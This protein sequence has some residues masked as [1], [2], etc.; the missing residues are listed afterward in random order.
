M[1]CLVGSSVDRQRSLCRKRL[2]A[3]QRLQRGRF[4]GPVASNRRCGRGPFC[5]IRL[6]AKGRPEY[7]PP[8]RRLSRQRVCSQRAYGQACMA[9]R[10]LAERLPRATSCRRMQSGAADA[11][12]DCARKGRPR[13]RGRGIRPVMTATFGPS[14]GSG[15]PVRGR[16]SHR[17]LPGRLPHG[18]R[19]GAAAHRRRALAIVA[20]C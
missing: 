16:G 4:V 19:D 3:P 14:N 13:A 8:R 11:F 20:R 15:T 10:H 7:S 18:A 12:A 9:C 2:E 1:A 17:C 6:A 5:G